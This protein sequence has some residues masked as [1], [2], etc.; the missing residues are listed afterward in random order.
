MQAD[1]NV[2]RGFLLGGT[3]FLPIGIAL[4]AVGSS[5]IGSVVTIVALAILVAGLHTYGRAGP[6]GPSE[7]RG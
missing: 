6:E 2:A 3:T 5:S 1:A 7:G 4:S